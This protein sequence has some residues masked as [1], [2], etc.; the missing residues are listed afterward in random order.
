M[1]KPSCPAAVSGCHAS[2]PSDPGAVASVALYPTLSSTGA[3]SAFQQRVDGK[4]NAKKRHSFTALSVTHRSSQATSHR[5]SMEISAPV[6]ISSSDPRAAARIGDLVHLSCSA[7]TQVMSLGLERVL[8]DVLSLSLSLSQ[9][10]ISEPPHTPLPISL[11]RRH[12]P[13]SQP[14]YIYDHNSQH[15]D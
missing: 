13:L 11:N 10:F 8:E 7:P 9:C 6:L 14:D 5:H 4:K 3:V 15:L 12:F 2:L 1:D